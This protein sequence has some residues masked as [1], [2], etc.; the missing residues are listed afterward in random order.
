MTEQELQINEIRELFIDAQDT[1]DDYN[2]VEALN[3]LG[4]IADKLMDFDNENLSDLGESLDNDL[5]YF[6]SEDDLDDLIKTRL[7]DTGAQGVACMLSNYDGNYSVHYM[8]GYGNL[9][10]NQVRQELQETITDYQ[11][12]FLAEL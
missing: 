8:D 6:I 4:Q 5:E 12:D 11:Q 10:D 7:D 1:L 9:D 2:E 3:Y